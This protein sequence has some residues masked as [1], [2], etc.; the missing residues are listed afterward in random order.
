MTSLALAPRGL[1]IVAAAV[2]LASAAPLV[3]VVLRAFQVEPATLQALFTGQIPG[4]IGSTAVLLVL[5]VAFALALGVPAA[6]LVERTDLPGRGLFRWLL[7]LPLAVPAYTAAVAVLVL[8]RRGGV[9]DEAA[10]A[11]GGFGRGSFPLPDVASPWLVA[12]TIA[13]CVYPYVYLLTGGALRTMDRT[14]EDA[15][16]SL[17]HGTWSIL[18]RV[19]LPLVL[20][21][22]AAGAVLV[23][24]Y[25]ISD[26]GTVSLLR[27]RTFTSAIFAQFGAGFDR[28]AA[29]VLCLVLIGLTLPV[30]LL[31]ERASRRVAR[32]TSTGTWRPAAPVALGPWRWPALGGVIALLGLTLGVPVITLGVLALQSVVAPTPVDVIWGARND[33]IPGLALTSLLLAGTAATA[34]LL[35]AL[36]PAWLAVRYPSRFSRAL[37]SVARIPYALPGLIVALGLVLL[38][39]QVT[40][41]LYSTVIALALGFTLRS[42]PPALTAGEAA[43]RSVQPGVDDAARV[44]GA[45]TLRRMARVVAPIAAPGLLAGWTLAFLTAMKELPT[46]LLLRPPGT[47][48]LPVHLLQAASESV[49]TQAAL[50]G[51]VLIGVTAVPVA[52][53]YGVAFRQRGGTPPGLA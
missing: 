23:A 50:A 28:S 10:M 43:V 47:S 18:W 44:L 31:G 16:R 17:G 4:L 34:A 8:V 48:T 38:L 32:T 7:A 42:L 39:L 24:L 14:L 40:P 1:V 41:F 51:I 19:T 26:F 46:A 25:V 33:T 22:I 53:L 27:Y 12:L 30:L 37:L 52:I 5:T 11:W 3:Y 35:A 36:A 13:A 49:Y 6:W 21:A 9:I 20:P 29:A 2:A 45:G 15:A